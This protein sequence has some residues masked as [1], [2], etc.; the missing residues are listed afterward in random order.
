MITPKVVIFTFKGVGKIGNHGFIDDVPNQNIVF[1]STYN[2]LDIP[3]KPF[4]VL[5]CSPVKT[6][7][8]Q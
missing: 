4:V 5:F 1:V 8:K 2:G 7:K 6:L 3:L